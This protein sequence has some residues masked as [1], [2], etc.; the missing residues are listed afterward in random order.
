MEK[1]DGFLGIDVSKGSADFILMDYEENVLESPFRLDDNREGHNKLKDLLIGWL[2]E[3]RLQEI[4]CGVESTG[5]YE[6]N[7]YSFIKGLSPELPVKVAR[8]NPLGVKHHGDAK[9][10]RTITDS[11]S[12]RT[13]ATYMIGYPEKV[14]YSCAGI[15]GYKSL[16]S[17][18]K[19]IRILK[20]QVNQSE[21][22]LEKLVYSSSPELLPYCRGGFPVWLLIMLSKYPVA[23]KIIKAGKGRLTKIKGITA[24]KAEAIIKALKGT[25]GAADDEFMAD[26]VKSTALRLLTDKQLI[27]CQKKSLAANTSQSCAGLLKLL[28]SITGVAD[29]SAAC[30]IIE[31]EDINRFESTNKLLSFAGVHPEYKKSGD[32]TY[33]NQMSKKGRAGLRDTLYNIARVAVVND[34][35]I[36]ALYEKQRASGK[37]YKAAI[38]AVMGKMLRIVYGVWKNQTPYKAETDRENQAKS[39]TKT[40][41]RGADGNKSYRF[42]QPTLTAPI[43]GRNYKKRRALA[44]PKNADVSIVHEVI[45]KHPVQS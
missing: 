29:Y 31:L 33:K 15:P 30:L 38:G 9:L 13:I 44:E 1:N 2:K 37:G 42:Q 17:R 12:A 18:Y 4:C 21:N 26:L 22:Q 23:G 27:E 7:W 24:E 39:A 16:R 8:I 6:N 3:N 20:K 32:G 25:T 5:G 19:F 11:V 10:T 43:S 45:N 35:H 34:P 28:T 41:K 14:N 40:A 36:R